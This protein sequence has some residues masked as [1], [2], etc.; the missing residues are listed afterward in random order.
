MADVK[1][2]S[3]L[4]LVA[5]FALLVILFV[6]GGTWS[7]FA[8]LAGAVVAQGQLVV[9]GKP[10]TIQHLDGGIVSSILIDDGDRVETGQPLIRLDDTLLNANLAIYQN[11]LQEGLAQRARLVAE[12]D[13]NETITW[14]DSLFD[15][16][17]IEA[18]IGVRNGQETLFSARRETRDGQI[19]QLQEKIRQLDNQTNGL[20]A[21]KASK[22][23]QLAFLDEEVDGIRA[24][25]EQGLVP[26][27][28]L[29]SLERQREELIGQNA[30]HDAELAGIQNTISE[31]QI[32]ILQIGREF[33][34]SVLAELRQV[35]Q[36][37]NDMTQQL[38]AT[39]EQLKRV[40]IKA[41][42]TGIIHELSVFTIGG[43]VAPAAP[44][45][46]I[47]PQEERLQV[48]AKVE[49]RSVDEIYPGQ[50]AAL[51]FSALNQRTT[52]E[53]TGQVEQ[54]SANV[55]TEEQT[56]A[57]YYLVR[58]V[59]SEEELRRLD[60]QLLIPGMPV[61]VFIKT[62]DRSALNYFLKP[63]LDQ[64]QRAFREE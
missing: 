33:R 5:G 38:Y 11:R 13:G 45:L 29:M 49:P 40:E 59:V 58:I 28:Q 1:T 37:V 32:Q 27:S 17:V 53:L 24:L 57:S 16:L 14:D 26:N 3:R 30:E 18:D 22:S 25:R 10:K 35:E 19:A 41:P 63:L 12:R 8:G 23:A 60:G 42:V 46:Q 31:T 7:Y 9:E 56:G 6:V 64:M 43:V 36:E 47:V 39:K 21:L 20:K 55:I 51:R 61:E 50:S 48:E 52:P 54:I 34:E 44:V 2:S 62:Q 4:A 15:L